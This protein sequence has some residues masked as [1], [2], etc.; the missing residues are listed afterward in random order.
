MR[1]LGLLLLTVIGWQAAAD[2]S[3]QPGV[4]IQQP[5]AAG[6]ELVQ[7]DVAALDSHR[8]PILDLQQTDFT[9]FE[10]GK[11]RPV[12]A[13]ARVDLPDGGTSD[14]PPEWAPRAPGRGASSYAWPQEGRLIIIVFDRSIPVHAV[15][16]ARTIASAVV[17]ALGPTDLA[18]IVRTSQFAGDGLSQDFTADKPEL[19]RAIASDYMGAT[20]PPSMGSVGLVEGSPRQG[21]GD[22]WCGICALDRIR[23]VAEAIRHVQRLRKVMIFI[24]SD[25]TTPTGR[26][27]CSRAI[28]NARARLLE[29]LDSANIT[30]H[31]FDPLGLTT[32]AVPASG[33]PGFAAAARRDYGMDRRAALSDLPEHTGGRTVL[34][35]NTPEAEIR[36]ALD[37]SRTYYLLGFESANAVRDGR[38]HRIEVRVPRRV[39]I[40]TWRK[41]YYATK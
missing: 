28:E 13:F 4:T 11:P 20:T 7:V 39:A 5:F 29:E 37:E 10:D 8:K 24:A 23:E 1:G 40:L 17:D 38:Y 32:D 21:G 30:V 34:N 16:S 14:S 36:T 33:F 31:T 9:V 22:C 19:R 2:S 15:P 3:A 25:M 26:G 18:A 27:A 12:L 35:S 6:T 41:G